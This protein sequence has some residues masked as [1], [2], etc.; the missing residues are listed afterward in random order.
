MD[1]AGVWRVR[2]DTAENTA[3]RRRLAV[4]WL[5]KTRADHFIM[6]D[7]DLLTASVV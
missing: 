1:T 7:D 2:T 5:K 4:T 3:S 6:L